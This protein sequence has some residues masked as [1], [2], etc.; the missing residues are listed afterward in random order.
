MEE[1]LGAIDPC[2]DFL[3]KVPKEKSRLAEVDSSANPV[4]KADSQFLFKKLDL[5]ADGWLGDGKA[6]GRLGKIQGFADD[7]K[8]LDLGQ[9]HYFSFCISVSRNIG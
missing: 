7:E 4:K 2:Y 3:S 5:G 6:S 9:G 1:C 8:G